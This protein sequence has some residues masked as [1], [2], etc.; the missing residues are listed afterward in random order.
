MKAIVTH[1]TALVVGVVVGGALSLTA[2]LH[3]KNETTAVIDAAVGWKA[4]ADRRV[5]TWR[6]EAP[7]ATAAYFTDTTR[8]PIP[9][10]LDLSS[11]TWQK[12]NYWSIFTRSFLWYQ[13]PVDWT[14]SSLVAYLPRDNPWDAVAEFETEA[15]GPS[16]LAMLALQQLKQ[17][18]SF[19]NVRQWVRDNAKYA[20]RA[21]FDGYARALTGEREEPKPAPGTTR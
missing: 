11:N 2:R 6:K 18:E 14:H 3:Q 20:S 8:V 4:M 9:T 13:S 19:E 10:D 16:H 12:L 17:G 5:A 15:D 21:T 1:C 7:V